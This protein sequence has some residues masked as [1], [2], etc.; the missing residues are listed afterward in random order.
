ME[1]KTANILNKIIS[2]GLIF[3]IGLIPLFFLPFTSEFYE[4]NKNILLLVVSGLL[5]VIWGLKMVLEKKVSFRRTLFDLPVLVIA[6][7]FILSTIF[8]STNKLE[9]LWIPGGTGTIIG[10]TILYFVMTNV[11]RDTQY[12][13][14]IIGGL[15]ISAIILSL[16][17]IYQFIGLGET[18]I[19]ANSF[20]AFLRLKSWTPAGGLLPLATFLVVIFSLELIQLI[21]FWRKDRFQSLPITHYPLSII[22]VGGLG[23][24]IWQ[25]F[26]PKLILL[27]YS[28]SWAIAVEAFKNWRMFL[29]GVGPTNFLDAFSQF[30]PLSYNLGNLWAIRFG[31]SGNYYLHLL[32]TVGILGLGAFL[33]LV[34][35]I[36]KIS[37]K[38]LISPGRASRRGQFSICNFFNSLSLPV[39][40]L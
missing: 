2:F 5:L 32:T 29:F 23:V 22:I 26:T 18:L 20:W 37:S 40:S 35:K 8:A 30:R 21:P 15:T 33:W 4:F 39:S 28:T 24:T 13:R 25:L 3:I 38:F 27:P 6:G 19:S 36:I 7:T 1:T 11:I 12:V 17:A 14:R 9:T 10:L 31:A 34:G 16:A